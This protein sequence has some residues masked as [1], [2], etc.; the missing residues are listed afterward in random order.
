MIDI[1]GHH[2]SEIVTQPSSARAPNLTFAVGGDF[3]EHFSGLLI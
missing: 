3:V 1:P 2:G